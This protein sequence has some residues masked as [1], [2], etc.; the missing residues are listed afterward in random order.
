MEPSI[1]CNNARDPWAIR[2]PALVLL[3]NSFPGCDLPNVQHLFSNDVELDK[4]S[5]VAQKL[6]IHHMWPSG[7]RKPSIW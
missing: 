3:P 5:L 4:A 6:I 1:R 7:R 2:L